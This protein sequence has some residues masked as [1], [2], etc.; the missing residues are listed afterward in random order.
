MLLRRSIIVPTFALFCGAFISLGCDDPPPN[1]NPFAAPSDTIKPP[2]I[3]SVPIPKGPTE[4][5]VTSEGPKVGFS[6]ILI[7]KNDGR[8]RLT[9]ALD[10]EKQ[11]IDGKD[12]PLAVDR[13]AKLDWVMAMFDGLFKLGATHIVVKTE[14]RPSFHASLSFTAQSKL[15]SAPACSIV[16]T[17]LKDRGTAVWKLAGGTATKRS[18]GFAGP[19]LSMTGETIEKRAAA[20]KDSSNIFLSADEGIEWGL[21]YDLG[22]S[23]KDLEKVKLDT[24]ILLQERPVAGHKV[25]L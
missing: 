18:K 15:T 3:D 23:T 20:C 1:K 7:E 11:H 24:F 4:F 9:K 14:T 6:P 25:A 12:V 16:A 21:V 2:P 5:S 13:K 8:E 17:V 22:A 19:D 10:E